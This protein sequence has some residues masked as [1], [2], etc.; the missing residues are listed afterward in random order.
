[1]LPV[2]RGIFWREPWLLVPDRLRAT[3]GAFTYF[4]IAV[5]WLLAV[6]ASVA[7]PLSYVLNPTIVSS[8]AEAVT[9]LVPI[10]WRGLWWIALYC[11]GVF[12]FI[13]TYVFQFEGVLRRAARTAPS[14]LQLAYKG[15]DRWQ[16][17]IWDWF[18]PNLETPLRK[19]STSAL[20]L[21]AST[22]FLILVFTTLQIA[23]EPERF[24]SPEKGLLIIQTFF[25]HA[26]IAFPGLPYLL[27]ALGFDP[28]VWLQDPAMT[29]P[30]VLGFR[31]MM[32]I[33]VFRAF[34]KL[35]GFTSPRILYRDNRRLEFEVS[36]SKK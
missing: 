13:A 22:I 17:A 35:L 14:V 11:I 5:S 6:L 9:S 29:S 3:I 27:G 10:G 18:R 2:P 4:M 7:F 15:L 26:T 8:I 31:I 1:M 21:L 36:R 24:A 12:A 16:R 25:G 28:I 33:V 20:W 19:A 30:I 34:W 32:L 23:Q